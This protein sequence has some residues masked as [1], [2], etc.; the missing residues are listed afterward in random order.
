[1][2]CVK[3]DDVTHG[4]FSIEIDISLSAVELGKHV[5]INKH[6][7]GVKQVDSGEVKLQLQCT[8]LCF[9]I[10]ASYSDSGE[11]TNIDPLHVISLFVGVLLRVLTLSFK[12]KYAG[13]NQ[14]KIEPKKIRHYTCSCATDDR[15]LYAIYSQYLDLIGS[16][17]P[18]YR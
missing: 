14:R 3:F 12:G 9:I 5:E 11:W 15:S 10:T 17:G 7:E 4:L 2:N 8:L 6:F 18:F 1:M 13:L 16:T